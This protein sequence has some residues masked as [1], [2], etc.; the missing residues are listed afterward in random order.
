MMLKNN[1]SMV[2]NTIIKKLQKKKKKTRT[3]SKIRI[4]IEI[5]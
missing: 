5:N 2:E 3:N 4:G 1:K